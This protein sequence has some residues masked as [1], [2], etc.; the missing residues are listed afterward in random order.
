MLIDFWK[1]ITWGLPILLVGVH[2]EVLQD[3]LEAAVVLKD[4]LANG[5]NKTL[6]TDRN[7]NTTANTIHLAIET[8]LPNNY[9]NS[10]LLLNAYFEPFSNFF[11]YWNSSIIVHLS[12]RRGF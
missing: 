2:S 4:Y 9:S 10:A 7:L 8:E 11:G 12:W 3:N 1:T 6:T 5:Y